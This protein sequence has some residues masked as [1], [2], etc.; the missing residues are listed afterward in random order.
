MAS[1]TPLPLRAF[2]SPCRLIMLAVLTAACEATKGSLVAPTD[3]LITLTASAELLTTNTT[4]LITVTVKESNGSA[5]EDGTEVLMTAS[6]G[7]LDRPKVR[8]KEGTATLLFRAGAETGAARIE[9]ASAGARGSLE[10]SIISEAVGRVTLTASPLSLPSSGGQADLTATVLASDGSTVSGVP[11][12]FNTTAGTLTPSSPVRTDQQGIARARLNTTS[13]ATVTARVQETRSSDVHIGLRH[14]VSLEISATPAEPLAGQ[15]TTFT[16]GH[17]DPSVPGMLSMNFGDGETADLGKPKSEL[18]TEHVYRN[19]GGY[20]ATVV[21]TPTSGGQLRQ[22]VRVEVRGDGA[23]FDL[24]VSVSPAEPTEGREATFT[25]AP[26]H[27]N[28]PGE[29]SIAFGDGDTDRLGSLKATITAV[30]IYERAGG[31][32]ATAIFDPS[33]GPEQRS[34][35]RVNVRPRPD[36]PPPPDPPPPDDPP[37]EDDEI[38][39]NEVEWLHADVSGWDVTSRITDVNI[40]DPGV[41][42]EHTK[43]GK[44]RVLDGVE[45]NPWVFARIDGR[46]YAAT[47]E[48]LRPGQTCKGVSADDIGPHTKKEPLD[49]WKPRAGELVGFMVSTL[50]RDSRR[51]SNERSNIVLKRWP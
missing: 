17:S 22:T 15:A 45:G 6:L 11:V 28:V 18:R 39:V 24:A 51:T 37:S 34:T 40:K 38:D 42:I 13:A 50:A 29:L 16:I 8:T 14:D 12:T 26:S 46:W 47:Y 27:P 41:C 21:F 4:A 7:Q 3:S 1:L 44:W 32:N 9:A 23:A 30:H 48:W 5:V 43:S 20:N 49:S 2:G 31:Y 19:A 25:I 33:E 10:L 36:S 35:I